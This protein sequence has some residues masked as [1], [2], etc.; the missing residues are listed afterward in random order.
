MFRILIGVALILGAVWWL[1]GENSAK[2]LL[3]EILHYLSVVVSWAITQL[4]TARDSQ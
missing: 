4:R 1:N 3:R 2:D